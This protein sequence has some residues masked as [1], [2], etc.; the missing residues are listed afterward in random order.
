MIQPVN[1]VYEAETRD[2]I[3]GALR[4]ISSLVAQALLPVLLRLTVCQKHYP[5]SARNASSGD[6]RTR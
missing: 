2:A 3:E 6:I 5:P 4:S 1:N